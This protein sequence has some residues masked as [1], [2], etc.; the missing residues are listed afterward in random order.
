MK[1]RLLKDKIGYLEWYTLNPT[2]PEILDCN[3]F[4]DGPVKREYI[5]VLPDIVEEFKPYYTVEFDSHLAEDTMHKPASDQFFFKAPKKIRRMPG[6]ISEIVE[7]PNH[8]VGI[9]REW[10]ELIDDLH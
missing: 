8:Y 1:Y 2:H 10:V 9:R 7:L 4:H 3:G 6:G 5:D